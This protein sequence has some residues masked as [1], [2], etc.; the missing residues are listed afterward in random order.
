MDISQ[1]TREGRK[2]LKHSTLEKIIKLP[3]KV[4]SEGVTTSIFIFTAGVPQNDKERNYHYD[5]AV[6]P[7]G[8]YP[9]ELKAS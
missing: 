6:P 9:K 7:L 3:E 5:E 8:I 2:L 1:L 4:F